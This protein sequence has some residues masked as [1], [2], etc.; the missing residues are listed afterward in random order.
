[1]LNCE[2][3][4]CEKLTWRPAYELWKAANKPNHLPN[5]NRSPLKLQLNK[6]LQQLLRNRLLSLHPMPSVF[7]IL[8]KQLISRRHPFLTSE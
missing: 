3:L 5:N 4:G 8:F 7:W 6:L 2:L 1:M